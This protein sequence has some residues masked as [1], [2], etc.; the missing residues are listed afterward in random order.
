[1]NAY[2][3]NRTYSNKIASTPSITDIH[4]GDKL[5][6]MICAIIAFFTCSV[7]VTVEKVTLASALFFIFF[8]VVGGMDNGSIGN[9]FG[10]VLCL[11]ITFIEFLTL[12]SMVAHRSK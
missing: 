7:M 2:F 12:K 10:L 8:G 11:L 4:V 3:E 1:M 6:S 9:L 5:I